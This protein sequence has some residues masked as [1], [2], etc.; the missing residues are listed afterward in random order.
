M[1]KAEFVDK[2]VAGASKRMDIGKKA[3]GEVIDIVFAEVANAIRRDKRFS[4][5]GFGT[6]N[7][8]LRKARKGRNPQTGEEIKIKAGKAVSFKAAPDLKKKI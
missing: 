7:L 6:F 4:Y 1:T 5:P 3:A 2:V 8:R